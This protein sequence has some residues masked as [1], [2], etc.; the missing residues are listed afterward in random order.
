MGGRKGHAGA[1]QAPRPTMN[2]RAVPSATL[3]PIP[4]REAVARG[5][6]KP[7]PAVHMMTTPKG[8]AARLTGDGDTPE[9]KKSPP[10][11]RV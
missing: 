7:P 6:E 4:A 10:G 9:K 5:A 2:H 3:C 11:G 8:F 1:P